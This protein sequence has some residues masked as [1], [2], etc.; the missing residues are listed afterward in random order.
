MYPD[1]DLV[2]DAP[3][4]TLTM[5]IADDHH[6][7]RDGMRMMLASMW[8]GARAQ[9][10]ADADSLLAQA[11]RLQPP[12]VA[13]VDLNMPGMD[14]GA[15]LASLAHACPRL[16]LVVISALTSPDIVRRALALP[17]VYAFVAKSSG[18]AALREAVCAALQ[19][20]KLAYQPLANPALGAP[21]A[22][23]TPRMQEIRVL[24]QQGLSNKHIAQQ[25]AL[26]EGTVKNYMSE[27]FRLLNVSNR[28]QA[29]RYDPDS[30]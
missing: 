19:G 25:L 11:R 8:P 5:L 6:L 14:R 29:A 30:A 22:G 27:I 16:P 24:L 10:A 28:T 26:S 1:N 15:R 21:D 9:E 13:L 7:V 12:A 18:S 23:L 2:I 20:R 17:T 4:S 3:G